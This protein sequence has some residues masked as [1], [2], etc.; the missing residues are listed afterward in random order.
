MAKSVNL[1]VDVIKPFAAN[2]R[3]IEGLL[4]SEVPDFSIESLQWEV[5]YRNGESSEPQSLL[6]NRDFFIYEDEQLERADEISRIPSVG[7]LGGYLDIQAFYIILENYLRNLAKHNQH[8]QKRAI[9]GRPLKMVIELQDLPNTVYY[10]LALH[11]DVREDNE[12]GESINRILSNGLIDDYGM[13]IPEGW[14]VK[15]MLIAA[16]HLGGF[17]VSEIQSKG[18][19]ILSCEVRN[20]FLEYRFKILKPLLLF[21]Q[22]GTEPDSNM[23]MRMASRGVFISRSMPPLIPHEY[24]I[25][26]PKY[27]KLKPINA[28]LKKFREDIGETLMPALPGNGPENGNTN[29]D[30]TIYN[31]LLQKE[32]EFLKNIGI[33]QRKVIFFIKDTGHTQ[34]IEDFLPAEGNSEM[35][36]ICGLEVEIRTNLT[37]TFGDDFVVVFDRHGALYHEVK[38]HCRHF[39]RLYYEAYEG[40]SSTLSMLIHPPFHDYRKKHLILSNITAAFLRVLIIDE[41]LQLNLYDKRWDFGKGGV[42][43]VDW[44][45][46]MQ[47]YILR[48]ATLDLRKPDGESPQSY[49]EKIN[50]C[51][52][53][54]RHH[55][56][57]IH[58]GV[59][60]KMGCRTPEELRRWV[61]SMKEDC[62]FLRR[63]V[64]H[65]G[66]GIPVNIPKDAS[67][68]FIG[69]TAVEHW[70]AS[71]GLK[72]KYELVQEL[73]SARG[74]LK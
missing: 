34:L 3:L 13:L 32:A 12:V 51:I 40:G 49:R 9:S 33:H 23:K 18:S 30:E 37:P 8:I 2:T 48:Q 14:G 44:L 47:I 70:I 39:D 67:V 38:Q 57:S 35:L 59:L 24:C 10:E 74:I 22:V 62:R 68:P 72:S 27:A 66:R 71:K 19:G 36:N 60:D 69:F 43:A 15:E 17:P 58:A 28:G 4:K 50:Q 25:I 5:V 61:K 52:Q 63:I 29:D 20:G 46:M 56:V 53:E 54:G 16:A 73:L 31:Y 7:I 21:V 55:I 11:L 41:R 64:V 6:L 26:S 42:Q 1:I 45:E 65:S